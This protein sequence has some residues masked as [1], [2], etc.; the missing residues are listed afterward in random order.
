MAPRV[1][2]VRD[3]LD[4]IARLERLDGLG[5]ARPSELHSSRVAEE[6]VHE[7][8]SLEPRRGEAIRRE[9]G[10]RPLD[11]GP[12]NRGDVP[13]R[14]NGRPVGPI[15]YGELDRCPRGSA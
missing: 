11:R 14:W 4:R 13:V 15:T 1:Q 6:F 5:P 2:R 12:V 8:D 3:E 7:I 9:E 10:G